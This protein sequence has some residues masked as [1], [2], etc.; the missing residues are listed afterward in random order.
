MAIDPRNLAGTAALTF[1]DEFNTLSL[2][3]G[4]SGTWST[5]L[6]WG[7]ANGHSYGDNQ[8]WYIEANYAPTASVR[9]WTVSSGVLSITAAKADPSIRPYI[10]NYEYTSGNSTRL[11]LS[12]RPTAI[13]R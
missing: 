13:S 9:P 5:N 3:S 2:R 10:N 12:A 11:I 6:W 4:S 8:Q 7:G 1:A